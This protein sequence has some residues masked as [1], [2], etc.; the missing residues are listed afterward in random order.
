MGSKMYAGKKS[1][2]A[3]AIVLICVTV[4]VLAAGLFTGYLYAGF[5][6]PSERMV[7][8]HTVCNE[9][10]IADYNIAFAKRQPSDWAT[11]A[12]GITDRKDYAGDP[13]CAYIVFQYALGSDNDSLATT[14]LNS[15]KKL[16]QE[17]RYANGLINGLAGINQLESMQTMYRTKDNVSSEAEGEG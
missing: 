10:D 16:N 6:T 8:L 14:A 5:K 1:V 12:K 15:L 2:L 11:L 7:R 17:G 13:T 3:M 9:R 4:V